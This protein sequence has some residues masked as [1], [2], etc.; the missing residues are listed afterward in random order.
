[1]IDRRL[2]ESINSTY[3]CLVVSSGRGEWCRYTPQEAS[4]NSVN[5]KCNFRS[6]NFD[7]VADMLAGLFY[8]VTAR[9]A[10]TLKAIKEIPSHTQS[11]MFLFI[12]VWLRSHPMV[13]KNRTQ[14]EA[15]MQTSWTFSCYRH[16]SSGIDDVMIRNEWEWWDTK[17]HP[18]YEIL[19]IC[20][21]LLQ[22][23]PLAGMD[24]E[25]D[26]ENDLDLD[27]DSDGDLERAG[28]LDLVGDLDL[29]KLPERD[30]E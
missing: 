17:C 26:L 20:S 27:R 24:L 28:E 4:F 11:L 3:F 1:M 7:M 8:W 15:N 9:G 29:E 6:W 22:S 10:S 5:N 19:T 12:F 18:S 14:L 16:L 23:L 21:F 13:A 30:L 2:I 25:G